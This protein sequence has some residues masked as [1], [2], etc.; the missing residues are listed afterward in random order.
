MFTLAAALKGKR[1]PV[2]EIAKKP[3]TKTA[4]SAAKNPSAASLQRVPAETE[5]A[6]VDDG[7]QLRPKPVRIRRPEDLLILEEADFREDLQ[8]QP[9]E[10]GDSKPDA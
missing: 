8:T 10:H 5:T 3:I 6:A 1:P 9:P 7:R 4:K 2:P